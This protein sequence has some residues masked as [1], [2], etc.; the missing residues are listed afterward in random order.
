MPQTYEL[1]DVTELLNERYFPNDDKIELKRNN[2]KKAIKDYCSR[3]KDQGKV[4]TCDE[5]ISPPEKSPS[6]R[7][8]NCPI[9]YNGGSGD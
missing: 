6:L 9:N 4:D 3:L 2:L 8:F 7:M 5:V 1:K